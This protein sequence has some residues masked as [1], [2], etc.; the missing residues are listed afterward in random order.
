MRIYVH[1]SL[2]STRQGWLAEE[3]SKFPRAVNA[4]GGKNADKWRAEVRE[5]LGRDDLRDEWDALFPKHGISWS[6]RG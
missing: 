5:R 4:A 1:P 6:F 3:I 2:S